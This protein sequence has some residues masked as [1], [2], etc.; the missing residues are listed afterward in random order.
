MENKEVAG[1]FRLFG[2]LVE[3]K[4]EK[5]QPI[6]YRRAAQV[7][8]TLPESIDKR[9]REFGVKSLQELPGIGDAISRKIVELVTT[10]RIKEL[11]ALR[12]EFPR[13]VLLMLRIPRLGPKKVKVLL[14]E[15]EVSS[16]NELEARAREGRVRELSG[17][18]EKS[19]R[20]IIE[21]I[22]LVRRGADRFLLGQV[23]P[24][25]D[26][27][28]RELSSVQGV[29]S[30]HVCG[31]VRR[32]RETVKDIDVLVVADN[33]VVVM[34]KFVS[35][36][37]VAAVIARG[38]TKAAARLS[39]GINVDVRV[40][41]EKSLGAALNYFSGSK[42]HN[43]H[44]RQLAIKKGWKLSEYGLFKGEKF[45]GGRS[46]DELYKKLGL[47]YVPPELREDTGEIELAA[48]NDLPELVPYGS[49][50]GDCHVHSTWSDGLN[51][52]EEMVGACVERNYEYCAI[53]DHSKIIH[54]ANGLD[55]A[56]LRKQMT[57]IDK[58]QKKFKDIKILKGVEVD[59][60]RDGSLD[61]DKSVLANLDV[62]NASIHSIFSLS[63][64][65]MTKRIIAA[66]ESGVVNVWSHPSSRKINLREPIVFDEAKVF[67]AAAEYGVLLEINSNPLRL[68]LHGAHV[69][70][71]LKFGNKFI[72]GSD[73]HHV[74]HLDFVRF[75]IGQARRGWCTA[76]D[77]VNTLPLQKLLKV[78]EK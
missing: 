31:S 5:W 37:L 68:D 56:R 2:D 15:L 43:V 14:D 76:K 46:E 74:E 8:E 25:A 55:A 59:I 28:V 18:G 3:L 73:A 58:V 75:G 45:V 69:K 64:E 27:L 61:L 30:V 23:V 50:R 57:A 72:I 44:L 36:K 17:F 24:V 19:E 7:I 51:T 67:A 33:P 32:Q 39:I 29:S 71:A 22:Q 42:A 9:A 34:E 49:L 13:D 60:L 47:Q 62:V 41:H 16:L 11:D 4:G 66:F 65:E 1:F 48:K 12:R 63:R 6:A 10:G 35:S 40:V 70:E 26:E 77:V 53:T 52:V 21:G 78:F 54:V 20:E 38:E